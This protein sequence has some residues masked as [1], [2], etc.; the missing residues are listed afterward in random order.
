MNKGNEGKLVELKLKAA[1][2]GLTDVCPQRILET[3]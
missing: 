2:E 3:T 1:L